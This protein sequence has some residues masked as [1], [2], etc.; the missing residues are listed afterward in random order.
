MHKDTA[1]ATTD[2]SRIEVPSGFGVR[3]PLH[4]YTGLRQARYR[5]CTCQQQLL[6]RAPLLQATLGHCSRHES[7]QTVPQSG[8]PSAIP[9][10]KQPHSTLMQ[11]AIPAG[12]SLPTQKPATLWPRTGHARALSPAGSSKRYRPMSS[13]RNTH[14]IHATMECQGRHPRC[15]RPSWYQQ[16]GTL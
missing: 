9:A 6:H 5:P 2:T 7:A 4:L 11:P 16:D 1:A 10:V 3:G 12:L 13:P 8:T 14:C 15:P